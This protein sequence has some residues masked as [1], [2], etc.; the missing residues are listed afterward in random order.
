VYV[1]EVLDIGEQ[2]ASHLKVLKLAF[3]DVSVSCFYWKRTLKPFEDR[4]K[5]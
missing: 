5:P 3:Q 1:L 4:L 2:I